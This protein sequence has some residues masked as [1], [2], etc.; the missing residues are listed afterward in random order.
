MNDK[1][2]GIIRN[3]SS[4]LQKPYITR[5]QLVANLLITPWLT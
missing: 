2:K 5:T 4:F 1:I 3:N